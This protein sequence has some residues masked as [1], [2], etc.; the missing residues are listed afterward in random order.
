M[1]KNVLS[2]LISFLFISCDTD[3]KSIYD[4]QDL[5]VA[6]S[7]ETAGKSEEIDQNFPHLNLDNNDTI[8]N[9]D[10][11]ERLTYEDYLESK[12]SDSSSVE[13][14]STSR[15]TL[16]SKLLDFAFDWVIRLGLLFTEKTLFTISYSEGYN[17]NFAITKEEARSLLPENITPI[18]L[19][20]LESDPE[21]LYYVTMYM[22]G[23]E[24]GGSIE[25][26][27]LFTYGRDQNGDLT[28]FF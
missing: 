25:R 24:S 28:M 10:E 18:K 6:N 27:D 21:P 19:K 7:G 23:M 15:R 1:Y 22:A 8:P 26:V 3:V 5:T 17:L 12:S 2:V 11:S 14:R 16:G 20:I 4:N 9:S 13:K